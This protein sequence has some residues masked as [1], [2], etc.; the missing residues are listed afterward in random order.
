MPPNTDTHPAHD[1]LV[2]G[3]PE[4]DVARVLRLLR[5][6][7]VVTDAELTITFASPSAT[8]GLGFAPETLVGRSVLGLLHPDE[9]PIALDHLAERF[10][11]RVGRTLTHRTLHA[12]GRVR[13][14]ESMIDV[15]E[16]DG[17]F[18]GV[19][20]NARD[21]TDRILEQQRL[22]R[23]VAF[24]RALVGLTNE[25]LANRLDRTFHQHA[26]ERAIALVPDA[27]GGSMMLRD[28]RDGRYDFVA[29]VGFDL[30]LLRTVRPSAVELR[31][32][33]PPRVERL[34]LAA[35]AVAH[36]APETERLRVV[37]R[38]A[39][40]RATLCVPILL[41][42]VPRGYL[43]LDNF[44]DEAAFGDDAQAIA[45]A[46]SAQV[47]VA[48]QRVMLEETLQAE[49]ARYERL[50][51]HDALTGLPNRRL[52]QDRLEQALAHARRGGLPV[53][54]AYIDLDGFKAVNDANGHDAGDRLLATIG[55]RLA[56]AVRAEDTVARLGGDEFG[57]VFVHQRDADEAVEVA[58]KLLEAVRQPLE[59]G[60]RVVRLDASVGVA[61]FPHA[62]TDAD[63]IM[64]AADVAM[65]RMKAHAKGGVGMA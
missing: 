15:L 64:R 20:F 39:D 45:T 16:E 65:Y 50:A 59:V 24:S 57:A 25:L 43:N 1:A 17:V 13:Y 62:G 41:G 31:R 54:V 19:V 12:D 7:L 21:V 51:G 18:R 4:R 10:A 56:A 53:A 23:E 3:L 40:I 35:D 36:P 33:D 32:A 27:Q 34:R 11:Q 38:V 55:G 52:F 29:A 49:R 61:L 58:R 14:F 48:L 2:T 46:I 37:G 60:G 9:R 30:D 22:E 5:D 42:G 26:L 63:A 47:A 6:V 8:D 28:D 44:E